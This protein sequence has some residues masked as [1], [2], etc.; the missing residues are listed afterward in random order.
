MKREEGQE[1][2]SIYI[3]NLGTVFESSNLGTA[4]LVRM[5]REEGQEAG[6]AC[7]SYV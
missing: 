7:V 1:A 3:S 4:C 5:K 6:T 2:S